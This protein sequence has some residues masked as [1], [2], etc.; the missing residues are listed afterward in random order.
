MPQASGPL[1]EEAPDTLRWSGWMYAIV[2]KSDGVPICCQ[3][4]GV[5]PDPVVVWSNESAAKAF[6]DSKGGGA[7]FQ[8]MEVNDHTMETL[9]KALGCSLDQLT[10]EQYP[11]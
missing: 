6:I 4:P 10:L 8:P 7:D 3:V 1:L 11:S 9:A 5:C 2:Y